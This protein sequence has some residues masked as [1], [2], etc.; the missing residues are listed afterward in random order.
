MRKTDGDDDDHGNGSASFDKDRDK[1]RD[2]GRDRARAAAH[3]SRGT[4]ALKLTWRRR[5]DTSRRTSVRPWCTERDKEAES[6]ETRDS[7]LGD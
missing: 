5:P 6:Q 4:K 7:R 1:D 3:V 2:R